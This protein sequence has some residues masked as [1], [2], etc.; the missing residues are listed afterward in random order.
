[1][2]TIRL[3]IIPTGKPPVVYLSKSDVGRQFRIELYEDDFCL[4][5]Q[6]DAEYKLQGLGWEETPVID[7]NSLLVTVTEKMTERSGDYPAVLHIYRNKSRITTQKIVLHIER[8][9]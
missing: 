5:T 6:T 8:G 1:M 3:N 7:N 2:Q 4:Y 9:T